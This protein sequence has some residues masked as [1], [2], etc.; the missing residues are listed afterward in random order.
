MGSS[1][2]QLASKRASMPCSIYCGLLQGAPSLSSLI[3]LLCTL[4]LPALAF[5][6][7]RALLSR[8]L[9]HSQPPSRYQPAVLCTDRNP[10]QGTC[11]PAQDCTSR[12]LGSDTR[13][14]QTLHDS[15]LAPAQSGTKHAT[16]GSSAQAWSS[17]SVLCTS[18]KAGKD[19]RMSAKGCARLQAHASVVTHPQLRATRSVDPSDL[20]LTR[21]RCTL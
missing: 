12:P 13:A 11:P 1:R 21:G 10:T 16:Q 8:W 19:A 7:A 4:L 18:A 3:I 5:A 15:S 14:A 17:A 20:W 6:Y 2:P 9:Q